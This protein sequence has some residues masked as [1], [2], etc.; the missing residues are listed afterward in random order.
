MGGINMSEKKK[1]V[2]IRNLTGYNLLVKVCHGE[3]D[4]FITIDEQPDKDVGVVIHIEPDS[5]TTAEI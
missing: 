2:W 4:V 5:I 1:L 3:K